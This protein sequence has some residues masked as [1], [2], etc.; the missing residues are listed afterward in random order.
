MRLTLVG[1]ER[2]RG[3]EASLH[4][5]VASL[6][7]GEQ[8]EFAAMV[9]HH[10]VAS[11]Y[12]NADVVCLPSRAEGVPM[13]LLEGMAFGLPVLATRVGGIPDLVGPESGVLV[14][15]GDVAGLANAIIGFADDPTRRRSMAGSARRR[16]MSVAD[17]ARIAA[18]WR[19]TYAASLRA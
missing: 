15:P 12:E 6:G 8:V 5:L 16:A 7:L 18:A 4:A 1:K 9:P 13:A 19:E 11:F 17:P 10:A 14:A 2:R 3:E